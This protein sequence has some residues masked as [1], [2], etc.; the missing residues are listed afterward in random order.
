MKFSKEVNNYDLMIKVIN[1]RE[2]NYGGLEV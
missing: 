1:I 2:Q